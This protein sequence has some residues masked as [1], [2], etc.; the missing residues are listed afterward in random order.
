MLS[1]TH[2]GS[3]I[4]LACGMSIA[5]ITLGSQAFGGPSLDHWLAV[6]QTYPG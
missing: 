1:I 2:R 5:G 4:G 6:A 3:G